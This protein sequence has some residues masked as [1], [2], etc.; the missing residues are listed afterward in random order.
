MPTVRE[1]EAA[2]QRNPADTEAFV[3][4]RK[5]Y[6][7]AQKHDRAGH[8]VR[9]ARPGDRGQRQGGRALLPGRRA[10]HRPA[11]RRRGR[12]GRPGQRGRP[13][14]GAHPRGR[15]PEG[16]LSRA[17]PHRRLHDDA[18]DGGGGGRAHPRSGPH[19][20][21]GSG[22]EPAVP[23]PLR[24][25]GTRGPQPAAAGQAG[26]GARQVDRV[27]AQ[28]LPR[29]RRLP[30]GRAPLRAGAGRDAATPRRRADLL[31]GL[32][33]VLGEKL[34]ELD[35]AAQRLAE[36]VPHPP[37]RREGAGAAGR[38]LRQPELD[39]RRR[40]R[41][42]G[43]HLLSSSR[44]A[45]RRRAT[46]RT[47]SRRCAGR[48]RRSPATPSRPSCSSASTTT[49]AASRSWIAT[50]ASGSRRRPP[51]PSGSTS[52]TSARSWPRAS[53][54]TSPRRSASTTRSRSSSRRAGPASEKLVELYLHGHE[55]AKLAELRERQLGAIADP[56][57]AR[58][59]HAGAGGAVPRPAGRSRS[60]GRLP[61]RGAGDRARE[62][63]GARRLRRALPREGR[64]GGAG[65]P[66]GVL[67]R[68]RAAGAA[69]APRS[70][71]RGSRRSPPSAR[72]SWATPSARS[73]AW[74][75]AEEIAPTYS[76][77]REAQR[78]LLLKGKSWDRLAALL[79]REAAAQ[80]DPAQRAEILR[81]VAQ[82]HREKLGKAAR[83]IEIY[84]DILRADPHDAVSMRARRR[85][86]RARGRL[87]QPGAAAARADRSRRHEAGARRPAAPG[88]GDL[89]RADRRPGAG[90]VG[91]ERDPAGGAR[92]PRHADAARADPR[93]GRAA[94]RAGAA[95]SI[96]TPSTPPTPTRSSQLLRRI[97]EILRGPL[98]DPPG[99]AAAPGR[100]RPARSRR[101][102]GARHAGRASTRRSNRYEDL[103]RVLDLQVERVVADPAQQAEYLRQLA[104]LV[105]GPLHDLA[106]ARH[107]WEQLLDL[108]PTD[109]EALDALARIFNSRG[110]LA[111][112]GPD[113]RAAD[114]AGR[115]ARAAPSTSACSAPQIF[116]EKLHDT[117]AG[118]AGAGA[119]DRRDRPAQRRR[120]RAPAQ[121][122]RGRRGLAARRQGRR[123]AAVPDRGPGAARA[124]ARWSWARWS[125]TSWATTRRRSRSSSACS[126]WTPTTW[127]RCTR[128]PTSTSRSAITSGSRTP[129]R[130]CWSA[131]P[132]PTSGAC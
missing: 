107:T 103:A 3:A 93:A 52:S 119:A 68:A 28:D 113:P 131:S 78:R 128:P 63:D 38:R 33:R 87:R 31:L 47:P 89:R 48:C 116:D 10:A 90:P 24:A 70:C 66:A 2:M 50:T 34:E 35:A 39:R 7:Q 18:G 99:A 101:R 13:R 123:A 16:H 44:G 46:P 60:G 61:A 55:Y 32:G 129:T 29:A 58:A 79:E 84:K 65:R 130:S 14:P 86:L 49:R 114:A 97:A 77:A 124:G 69:S 82:I 100:G 94:G 19:R 122:L 6:R 20:R 5:A 92:R 26:A 9:D 126:R 57:A 15:A 42:R 53:W 132:T 125:A 91:G 88:A 81:R 95:C 112:A 121:L 74:Q 102:Q 21:A 59:H 22:D 11:G 40:R 98:Q 1:Y 4:L 71:C 41:A 104:R 37:A 106:R 109:A 85:D 83:A 76:R 118:R 23:Q 56:A 108:L 111:D 27:G 73:R 96:S 17:G 54:T 12:R 43:R 30:G 75:R 115:G 36:V 25:A 110:R 45:A 62:P 120:P 80:P 67:V 127:T 105:E 64:L 117:D 8:A 51:R 72:S